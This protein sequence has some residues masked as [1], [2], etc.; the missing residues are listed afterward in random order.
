MANPEEWFSYNSRRVTA[1]SEAPGNARHMAMPAEAGIRGDTRADIVSGESILA[2][3]ER[4]GKHG[5]R[6]RR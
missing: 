1:F 2:A 5:R 6:Q 3:R 4:E